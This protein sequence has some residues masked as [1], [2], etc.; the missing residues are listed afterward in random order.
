LNQIQYYYQ[1]I[2]GLYENIF[3]YDERFRT[4]QRTASAALNALQGVARYTTA[5]DATKPKRAT[6]M[7]SLKNLHLTLLPQDTT[8]FNN[9][10]FIQF[11][12]TIAEHNGLSAY[13]H[14]R[15]QLFVPSLLLVEKLCIL[16]TEITR[17]YPSQGRCKAA[18]HNFAEFHDEFSKTF[19]STIEPLIENTP[20]IYEHKS[21]PKT[22]AFFKRIYSEALSHNPDLTSQLEESDPAV[23]NI[24][25]DLAIFTLIT[26]YEEI[27]EAFLPY[28]IMIWALRKPI[29]VNLQHVKEK[30]LQ[31][32]DIL[33][34][35][36]A[37]A[38]Y[39]EIGRLRTQFQR[40]KPIVYSTLMHTLQLT[41]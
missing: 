24:I 7:Q 29:R 27:P 39:I 32:K 11:A 14:M 40:D 37:H 41:T 17:T 2:H 3:N 1:N 12:L 10:Y 38:V 22:V 33:K 30:I 19:M 18:L 15:G 25:V 13:P 34:D 26:S 23:F 6:Y 20:Y 31:D 4:A 21:Y 8:T 28:K 5:T 35:T 16:E 36:P 9:D